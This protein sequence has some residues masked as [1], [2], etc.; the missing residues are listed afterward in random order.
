MVY[1]KCYIRYLDEI[2]NY[3]LNLCD[4]PT[5][6]I[7]E[8]LKSDWLD[9]N[10]NSKPCGLRSTPNFIYLIFFFLVTV[11]SSVMQEKVIIQPYK[12]KKL[13]KMTDI[14]KEGKIYTVGK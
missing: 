4:W 6:C 11:F 1:L 14:E 7:T 5:L 12:V 3:V 8:A 9:S 13:N 10:T 2:M